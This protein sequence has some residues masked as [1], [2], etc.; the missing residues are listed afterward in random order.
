M[1]IPTKNRRKGQAF[2][3]SALTLLV[4][5][6]ML[7]GILDFGQFVYFQTSLA[8][9]TRVAARYAILDP[10][11]TDKIKNMAIYNTPT[12]AEGAKK[13]LSA[14]TTSMITIT[15]ANLGTAEGRVTVTIA[16]YPI[17]FVTPGLASTLNAP[18]VSITLPSEAPW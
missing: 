7:L 16:N 4:F 8:E 5:L 15:P 3:E 14:M 9:R 10:T 2:V 17:S 1:R 6:T 13:V 12:P 11:Q 18:R